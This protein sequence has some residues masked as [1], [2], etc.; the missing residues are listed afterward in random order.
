MG[1]DE[2]DYNIG[3]WQQVQY[4]GVPEYCM[5]CRHQG[6]HEYECNIKKRDEEHKKK[7]EAENEKKNK[8]RP[9]QGKENRKE[10]DNQNNRDAGHITRDTNQQQ[11]SGQTNNQQEEQWQVQRRKHI[12][13]NHSTED[14]LTSPQEKTPT[15]TRQ[16]Q[17]CKSGK[18]TISNHNTYINLESQDQSENQENEGVQN[19]ASKPVKQSHLGEGSGKSN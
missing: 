1:I 18:D 13:I 17:Q 10:K 5:Y 15:N 6:H 7:K 11:Q 2:D 8:T 19:T 14:R 4:E 12:K 16:Q 3:R 9:E